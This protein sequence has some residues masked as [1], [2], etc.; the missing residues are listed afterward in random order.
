MESRDEL[1]R[2]RVEMLETKHKELTENVEKLTHST[3]ELCISVKLM[4][5]QMAGVKWLTGVA[6]AAVIA[7]LIKMFMG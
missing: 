3:T 6:A 4:S 7:Q 1:I 2:Y 5:Q